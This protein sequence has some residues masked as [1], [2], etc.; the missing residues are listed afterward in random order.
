MQMYE[1][2][3]ILSPLVPS[4]EFYFIRHCQQIEV[5]SWVIVDVSYDFLKETISPSRCWKLPSGC[6]IQDMPNGCS[7]VIRDSSN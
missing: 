7:K 2:M 5:G 1:E 6:I 3:H 4:R